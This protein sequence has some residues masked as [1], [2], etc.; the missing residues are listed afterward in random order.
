MTTYDYG[1]SSGT[2][3]GAGGAKEQAKQAAGTA[4]DEGKHVADVAKSEAQSVAADAQEQARNL[5]ADA[6]T[7]I[8]EQSRSQLESL[9][10]T[11]QGFAEDLEKMARGEGTGSGLAHDVVSQVSDRAKGLSSQ[12]QGREPS[13]V[14]DQARDLARRRPG[15]FLLGAL[16]AGV[17][18]GRLARGAKDAGGSSTGSSATPTTNLDLPTTSDTGPAAPGM[19][20]A[21]PPTTPGG[22]AD[23]AP[24]AGTAA[25]ADTPVYPEGGS[26]PGGTL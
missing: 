17:V 12:L 2:E 5:V 9:V 19:Y 15:T 23:A 13:E 7:Q 10:S 4:A 6:R 20:S 18:A 24:L 16:A 1:T 22:A 3:S 14:L 25:P 11:M 8:Q 21:P 26:K